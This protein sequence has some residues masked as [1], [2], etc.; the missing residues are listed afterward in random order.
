MRCQR[1]DGTF[2][3]TGGQCR[4]GVQN[5]EREWFDRESKRWPQHTEALEKLAE[6]VA[7]LPDDQRKT[8]GDAISVQ[9]SADGLRKN[10][11]GESGE[12]VMGKGGRAYTEEESAAAMGKQINGW[13]RLIDKGVPKTILGRNGKEYEVPEVVVPEVKQSSGQIGY[14]EVINGKPGTKFSATDTPGVYSQNR[15][16]SAD[17]NR[18]IHTID[19]F[20]SAQTKAGKSWP[21]QELPPRTDIELDFD[22]TW[23]GLTKTEINTIGTVGLPKDGGA[24]KPGAEVYRFLQKPENQHLIEKRARDIVERYVAQGG[25]SG[26]SGLPIG[27]PGLK[28]NPGKDE[29][30]STVDHFNPISGSKGMPV[31]EIRR[32]FDHKGNFLLAEEGPNQARQENDWGEWVD[33]KLKNEVKAAEKAAKK[34]GGKVTP[35]PKPIAK[36]TE[37]APKPATFT[38]IP[39]QSS[40]DKPVGLQKTQFAAARNKMRELMAMEGLSEGAAKSQLTPA[41][42]ELWE[43]F[44]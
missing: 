24:D 23:G 6:K 22:K 39:S 8:I 42:R 7:G 14:R 31:E 30:K 18:V 15:A 12:K 19:S 36:K 44:G 16:T 40:R 43:Q 21:T 38:P 3:G 10:W 1:K 29:E 34:A 25:R 35:A 20:R 26:V 27:L 37:S 28:A 11:E 13:S 9:L 5:E 4:I 32:L 2:Y 17:S 41:Q 33:K